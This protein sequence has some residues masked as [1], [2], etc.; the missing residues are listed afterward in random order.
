MRVRTSTLWSRREWLA[1]MAGLALIARS[2]CARSEAPMKVAELD[3]DVRVHFVEAGRGVPL[4]FV[5]GS[6]GDLTYWSDQIIP[7]S[8]RFHTIAYSRRYNYPNTNAAIGGYSAVVDAED[9]AHLI[10][11]LELGPCHLV[12]HSYGALTA[13]FLTAKRPELVRTLT[14]AEPPAISLLA[15][16]PGQQAA[17]GRTMLEDLT[18]RMVEPMRIAFSEGRREDGV[19]IFIDFVLGHAGAWDAM[20][21]CEKADTLRNAEEWDVML[22]RGELFPV[23]APGIVSALHKPTLLL[24]GAKSY[25]FLGLIDAALLSLLPDRHRIVFPNAG[26][27]MWLQ[28]PAACRNAVFELAAT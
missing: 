1:G 6:L 7:F 15:H 5:H 26:H 19:R 8:A 21:A 4:I 10:R 24:S 25:P 20:S 22:P 18:A 14:L 13:L 9:L 12:G 11:K 3:G 28:E 2:A 27:Q 23:I 16:V 17:A